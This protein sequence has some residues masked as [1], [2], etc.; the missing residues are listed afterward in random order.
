V[1]VKAIGK[2][3]G[4]VGGDSDLGEEEGDVVGINTVNWFGDFDLGMKMASEGEEGDKERG[5]ST[6]WCAFD[7]GIAGETR[8]E[9]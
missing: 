2:V 4:G 3:L 6:C 8:G 1:K 5:G 7:V 9:S